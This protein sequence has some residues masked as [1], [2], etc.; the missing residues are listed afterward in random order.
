MAPL[1]PDPY[2]ILGVSKD[3]QTPEIRSSYRKL[4]LKCHPDKVTDPK[5]KAEKQDEFQRVQQA[6]E[7]LNND[8]ERQKYDDRVKLDDLRRQVKEKSYSSSPRPSAK[9]S[10]EFQI[11]TPEMRSSAFKSSP[12]P[13]KVHVFTRVFDEDYG[14]RGPR[15]FETKKSS[16]RDSS[17]SER[18]SKREAE[19]EK[20]KDREREKDKDRERRRKEEDSVRRK[21]EKEALKA[22]KK[23]QEKIRDREIK[24]DAEE[25]YRQRFAKPSAD[26]YDDEPKSERKRSSKKH[27]DKAGR[28]SPREVPREVPR[29]EKVAPRPPPSGR[30]YSSTDRDAYENAAAYVMAGRAPLGRS[31]SYQGRFPIPAAPSPPPTK[32]AFVSDETDSDDVRR[33]AAPSR[34]GSGDGPRLSRERSSYRKPSNE[35]LEDHLPASASS[36]ARHT[37]SFN[38]AAGSPPMASS[39]PRFDL[40]RTNTAPQ[41]GPSRP[42]HGISRAQTFS[43]FGDS[44]MPRGRNRSRLQAQVESSDSEEEFERERERRRRASRRTHSPEPLPREHVSRYQVDAGGRTRRMGSYAEG[45]TGHAFYAHA[46]PIRVSES[47]VPSGFR[48]SSHSGAAP[49]TRYGSVKT[50]KY[51][52]VRYSDYANYPN[53]V[54][55]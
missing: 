44:A 18:Y 5:L 14:S 50:S 13:A 25:K 19:R 27:D 11:R 38:P 35:V 2:K 33:S 45:D 37:S 1:P 32:K 49:P 51:D 20:D 47:R 7:L 36:A 55:A 16:K 43:G 4:V 29:E 24:R 17:F 21:M 53:A 52:A 22:E 12:S 6:Y 54:R 8:D 34:R 31:A 30:F 28:V 39:P 3:A 41:P 46:Y 26:N 42:T 40:P 48:E 15:L 10:A 23:R 9:H